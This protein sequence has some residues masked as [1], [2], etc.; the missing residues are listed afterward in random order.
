VVTHCA[1]VANATRCPAWQARIASRDREVGLA[2]ARRAEEHH[3]VLR[4]DEVQRPEVGDHVAFQPSR[5]LE[6]ELLQ[7]L[8]GREPRCAD[9]ALP[10]VGLAGGD[11]TLQAG[12]EELLV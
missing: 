4:G 12:D 6:V 3:V 1:A 8:A 2:G 5:M 10:T 11:L 7:R 9:A